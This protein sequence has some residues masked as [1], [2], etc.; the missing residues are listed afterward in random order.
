MSHSNIWPLSIVLGSVNSPSDATAADGGI[1]LLG[2]TDKIF[3]WNSTDSGQWYSNQSIRVKSGKEVRFGDADDSNYLGL[4]APTTVTAN[5]VWT[6]PSADGTNGQ[7]LKTDGSAALGWQTLAASAT[8]DTTNASNISSGTLAVARGGTGQTTYTDGQ[9]LI[10][11]TT[12]NTLT[13][14]TLTAGS[15]ISITNGGGSITIAASGGAAGAELNSKLQSSTYSPTYGSP[16]TEGTDPVSIWVATID[17]NNQGV[18]AKI[19]KNGSYVTV[20]IA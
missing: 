14:A 15:G 12:G 6:L 1:T 16:T 18:F 13:K 3:A 5:K 4:K 10:G 9:L 7:V 11:N 20:Q 17:S 19:K 2:T 8:T